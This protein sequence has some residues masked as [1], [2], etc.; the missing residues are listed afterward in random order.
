MLRKKNSLR[1]CLYTNK[2]FDRQELT[3]LVIVNGKLTVDHSKK[4]PGRGYWL[5][6]TQ[7]TLNDPKLITILTKR[8]KSYIDP[9]FIEDLKNK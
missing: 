6:V 9:N 1:T 8:T 5:K 4:M 3:R 7:E 2:Q